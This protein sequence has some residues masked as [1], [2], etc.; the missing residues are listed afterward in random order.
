MPYLD[1]AIPLRHYVL[2]AEGSGPEPSALAIQVS[3]YT[4]NGK[5]P[6][7]NNEAERYLFRLLLRLEF[8]ISKLKCWDNRRRL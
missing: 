4:Q 8:E 3:T 2:S 7:V 1:K 6:C 5:K